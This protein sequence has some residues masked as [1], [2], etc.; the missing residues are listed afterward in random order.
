MSTWQYSFKV[1]GKMTFLLLV[2]RDYPITFK[3][4]KN[5]IWS[6]QHLYEASHLGD[7]ECSTCIRLESL[8]SCA[9]SSYH[10]P[11]GRCLTFL[12]ESYCSCLRINDWA[13]LP[14]SNHSPKQAVGEWMDKQLLYSFIPDF[15]N[16]YPQVVPCLIANTSLFFSNKMYKWLCNVA[17]GNSWRKN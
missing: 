13:A 11:P 7:P 12:T 1:L 4:K 14:C 15:P 6:M 5:L 2:M 10:S 9:T 8:L 16:L 17:T 3:R